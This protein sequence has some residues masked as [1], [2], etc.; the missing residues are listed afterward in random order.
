MACLHASNAVWCLRLS[1]K[2]QN[3]FSNQSSLK[4]SCRY[5]F[6]VSYL[7]LIK[8][9][10]NV[11]KAL[12]CVKWVQEVDAISLDLGKQKDLLAIWVI[13]PITT[14][15]KFGCQHPLQQKNWKLDW[16]MSWMCCRSKYTA[17][18]CTKNGTSTILCNFLYRMWLAYQFLF[19]KEFTKS[20]HS[21]IRKSY[22]VNKRTL[23]TFREY[24]LGF[25]GI[26]TFCCFM[27]I[28][29]PMVQTRYLW[30]DKQWTP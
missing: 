25:N 3:S 30:W 10:I 5:L 14:N 16:K 7:Q 24:G 23:V 19:I 27:N 22:E 17:H 4:I 13:Q 26:K 28:P 2:P 21:P 20:N 11:C 15:S 29:E 6:S 12:Y 18:D 8:Q 9:H 1:L